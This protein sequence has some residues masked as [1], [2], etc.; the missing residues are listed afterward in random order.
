MSHSP[1]LSESAESKG[2]RLLKLVGENGLRA[3]LE[4]SFRLVEGAVLPNR[5]LIT[6][7]RSQLGADPLG[8]LEALGR[9][10]SLPV[11]FQEEAGRYLPMTSFVHLGF[12]EDQ[13]RSLYKLYL[14]F[15]RHEDSLD[16]VE[17]N[18]PLPRFVAFKW[19]P[20]DP[21]LQVVSRYLRFPGLSARA[22]FDRVD[23]LFASKELA[24]PHEVAREILRLALSRLPA[25][26]IQY[27]EVVEPGNPRRSFDL[28]VYDAGLKV[29]DLEP[30]LKKLS[31]HLQI[32]PTAFASIYD[33]V[34]SNHLGHVAGG[35]HR[36]GKPFFTIYHNE[37]VV[38]NPEPKAAPRPAFVPIRPSSP[39]PPPG[40]IEPPVPPVS[41]VDWTE[42][43]D[44]YRN[45]CLWPYEPPAPTEGKYRPVTLL[46]HSFELAGLGDVGAQLIAAL[47][48]AIGPFQTVWGV[49]WID[50]RLAWEFYF[51]DYERLER[52][53]SVTRVLD[54]VRP[55]AR[56]A[57]PIDEKV[58]YFMFSLDF[59]EGVFKEG[60]EVVHLYLGNPGSTVSSGV[61]YAQTASGRTLENF[62]FF[63][64]AAKQMD[65]VSRKVRCSAYVVADQIHPDSLL[66]PELRRCQTICVANKHANDTI[67]FSGVNVD[68]L[69]FFLTK[70]DYPEAIVQFVRSSRDRFDHLLF[71]VGFDYTTQVNRVNLI[72]SGFYGVF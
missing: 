19:D 34:S 46:H 37:Y 49:K 44:L 71:D 18:D 70:L 35:L 11:G 14:E 41:R 62:Y 45:Y 36:S 5:F 2:R 53:V 12:E 67:Y 17:T 27:L 43:G 28:N 61:S 38:S 69:L 23:N 1:S 20:D 54:A 22:L 24:G 52:V 13:T 68:Q 72:K 57:I 15:A 47:Q 65:E 48:A 8:R 33:R 6:F 58:P 59:H 26:E 3:K 55:F 10:L 4:R 9:S 25:E 39:V 63:F 50:G 40:K 32:P 30:A 60:I 42:P 21:A 56:C 29:A 51:Y 7:P 66:W 16:A 64:D 31:R